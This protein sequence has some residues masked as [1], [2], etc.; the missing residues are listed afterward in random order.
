MEPGNATVLVSDNR[1]DI[2]V[3]DQQ[4]QRT[5]QNA[6]MLTGIAPENVHL[7]MCYLGA[8]RQQRQRAAGGARGVHCE[9]GARPPGEDD[10]EPRG[11]LG[12]RDDVQSAAHWQVQGG[13]RRER[14]ADCDGARL[15]PDRRRGLP[16]DSRGIAM[17]PH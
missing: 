3:G 5:L 6:G 16:A 12:R 9:H 17:P 2:W 14:V 10:V 4:P 8:G 13:A 7:H 1:V 15:R 11:G